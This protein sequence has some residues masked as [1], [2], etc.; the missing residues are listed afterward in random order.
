MSDNFL[1]PREE[2]GTGAAFSSGYYGAAVLHMDDAPMP[3]SKPLQIYLLI[4]LVITGVIY[5]TNQWIEMT[6]ENAHT[7]LPNRF[8]EL[9]KSQS[10]SLE[11]SASGKKALER[12]HPDQAVSEFRKA[13]QAQQSAEGHEN[14]GTALLQMGNYDAAIA[15]FREATRVDPKF[16]NAY[17]SWGKTLDSQGKPEEAANVYQTALSHDP[18]S[19]VIHYKLAVTLQELE[20]NAAAARH[21]AQSAGNAD[22]AAADFQQ[23]KS[24]ETN[25]LQHY[26]RASRLG[27]NTADFWASYGEMLNA[28][29]RFSD[30]A[31]ALNRAVAADSNVAK[32]HLQLA[33][34]QSR[35]GDYS[36]AI[37]H[38]EKVLSLTPDNPEVLNNLAVLYATATNAEVRSP[39]MAVLLATRACD[40][41]NDQN[42]RF[43]DTLSRS[44]AAGKEWFQANTWADKAIKRAT[45]LHDEELI[46]ELRPRYD[47][48]LEH[49]AE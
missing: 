8:R 36:D 19:G 10:L 24:F 6:T 13:L 31:S 25:A 48:Y 29:G 42:A 23:S 17:V 47:R 18:D 14:L 11:H 37:S 9:V 30:A 40:A 16:A 32:T 12:K 28:Q 46:A 3:P 38:Y 33:L 21:A 34:A 20:R 26:T 45:Q 35:L 22:E 7:K 43:M 1:N 39:K 41:T 2:A 15:Q 27:I 5:V 49:K 44:Y 4:A